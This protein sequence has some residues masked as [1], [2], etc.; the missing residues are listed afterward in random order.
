[1]KTNDH[2]SQAELDAQLRSALR[3]ED[4]ELLAR[5]DADPGI[6]ATVRAGFQ[7]RTAW[8]VYVTSIVQVLVFGIC[9]FSGVHFFGAESLDDRVLW[10]V[11]MLLT[12]TVIA[13]IKMMVWSHMERG[14]LRREIKRIELQVAT[15]S[16]RL[17]ERD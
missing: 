9:V 1:M 8:W 12:G 4:A 11:L 15:L 7:G 6:L 16:L 5:I 3:A 14:M 17:Q 2:Q 13:T 10:G